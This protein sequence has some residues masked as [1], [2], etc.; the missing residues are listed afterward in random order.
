MSL[1]Q[2]RRFLFF[3]KEI[4]AA[5]KEPESEKRV[6]S[7]EET[8]YQ[9]SLF[10]DNFEPVVADAAQSVLVY[11][12]ANGLIRAM[13]KNG[14]I[15]EWNAYDNKVVFLKKLKSNHFLVTIGEDQKT[16]A[17]ESEAVEPVVKIWRLDQTDS[18]GS[19]V[20]SHKFA[21]FS[22]KLPPVPISC[23]DVLEDLSQLV[24]G[25]GNGAVLYFEGDLL[26]DRNPK[27]LLLR[28]EGSCVT[29]LLFR[30]TETLTTLF[31]TNLTSVSTYYTKRRGWPKE[32]VVLDPDG[33]CDLKCSAVTSDHQL[34]V[35]RS[36]ACYFHDVEEKGPCF[37]FE[38]EKKIIRWFNNYLIVV[39]EKK[40]GVVSNQVQLNRFALTVYDIR[41]KFIAFQGRFDDVVE[42]I[43]E[44]GAIFVVTQ[45]KVY[46]LREK[47]LSTKM[48]MLFKKHLYGISLSL[49]SSQKCDASYITDI[50]LRYGDYLYQK[51]DFNGA[52]DQYIETIGLIEPSFVIRKFLDAQRI[53]NL[54]RYLQALH[55]KKC[56]TADHTTLLLNCYTKL[57]S[58][59]KLDEF[60]KTDSDLTFDVETA[61]RVCR[62]AKYYD[63]ALY[64]AKKHNKTEDRLRTLME[65]SKNFIDGVKFIGTLDF[66]TAE[67]CLK[68]YGKKLM[69]VLPQE[70]TQF[71]MKLCT[72]YVPCV[73]AEQS[74]DECKQSSEPSVST[75]QRFKADPSEFIH[76][77]VGKP[78]RLKVFLEHIVQQLLN[79][80]STVY[81]TLLE[82]YLRE[83]VDGLE[84]R[85]DDTSQGAS[86]DDTNA[87]SLAQRIMGLLKSQQANYDANHALVLAKMYHFEP[88]VIFLYEKLRLYHEIVQHH[89]ERG[90]KTQILRSCNKYRGSD[91][92]LWL[93]ALTYFVRLDEDC[94]DE[95]REIL[96]NIERENLLPPLMVVQILSK[97]P[98]IKLGVIKD[99]MINTLQRECSQIVADEREIRN[100][101]ED[102]ER[103]R[104]EIEELKTSAKTFQGTKCHACTSALELPAVHFLCMHSYHQRC[105]VDNDR[106]CPKC[107]PEFRKVNEMKQSMK[108][109]SGQHDKFFKQLDACPDGFSTVAEYFGR[110]L[111]NGL[112][113]M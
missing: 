50:Y 91:E 51:G 23:F 14:E 89:M 56:A 21:V 29:G 30:E 13:P 9:I 55:E 47:D 34:V 43:S 63:H 54:T 77:F 88:G 80:S 40:G 60:I 35:G 39:T 32:S 83:S 2:W 1:L 75:S 98:K 52:I 24:V 11:G 78:K 70:T 5:S 79:P 111:I 64:L 103:M 36:E 104:D 33:G 59:D 41:D 12:D 86:P 72:D 73:E 81:N 6:E 58:V 57:K 48:Q 105:L 19:P 22:A 17:T 18:Q 99:F 10:D 27:R 53:H 4:F 62:Q 28:M 110:G 66:R 76:L 100:Y 108:L 15:T 74:A 95:I 42:V 46:Q 20:C 93:Q 8:E 101:Q 92:S 61:I 26:R 67:R 44:W 85:D 82:L 90:D 71:L 49:A 97:N 68:L 96:Q 16:T 69:A 84:V 31:V 25:L 45:Q 112:P 94:S 106:E 3:E 38:G 109:S 7:K 102:T 37:G 107:A 113:D 87:G 65:G